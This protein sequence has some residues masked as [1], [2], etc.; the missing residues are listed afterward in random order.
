MSF[1]VLSHFSKQRCT[2]VGKQPGIIRN[3]RAVL[4]IRVIDY[5]RVM[6]L[7]IYRLGSREAD[8]RE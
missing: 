3:L 5:V 6:M 7:A 4:F 2:I 1:P 8:Q